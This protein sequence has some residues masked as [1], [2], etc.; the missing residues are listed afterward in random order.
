M[1]KK[2]L[3]RYC[4]VQAKVWEEDKLEAVTVKD[5]EEQNLNSEEDELSDNV[6]MNCLEENNQYEKTQAL[7]LENPCWM[8]LRTK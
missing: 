1:A 6:L 2:K 3:P 8:S 5:E 4:L 7:S